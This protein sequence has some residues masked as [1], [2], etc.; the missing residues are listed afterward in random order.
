MLLTSWGPVIPMGTKC[1]YNVN[2]G[3][4]MSPEGMKTKLCV[5]VFIF[6]CVCV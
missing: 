1:A 4:V 2:Y 5:F 6:V 3:Y